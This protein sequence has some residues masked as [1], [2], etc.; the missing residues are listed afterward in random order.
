MGIAGSYF[1]VSSQKGGGCARRL[2]YVRPVKTSVYTYNE[3]SNEGA[4]YNV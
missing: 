2:R 3:M 1:F 4:A